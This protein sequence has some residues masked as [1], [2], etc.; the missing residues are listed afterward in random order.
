MMDTHAFEGASAPLRALNL[1]LSPNSNGVSRAV[2]GEFGRHLV[3]CGMV[4]ETMTL[5]GL[6]PIWVG[7]TELAELPEA[8]RALYAAAERADCVAIT[9]P[10]YCYAVGSPAKAVSEVIG[11]A[12]QWKPLVLLSAAGSGRSHLVPGGLALSLGFENST[13]WI[14]ET[15]LVTS[16]DL[17]DGA[18]TLEIDARLRRLAGRFSAFARALRPFADSV[19]SAV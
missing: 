2:A 3:E 9:S 11:S 1:A 4:V 10:V 17:V 13:V 12:M 19:T 18:P 6:P 15:V 16:D 14:P 5:D 8:W 7:G